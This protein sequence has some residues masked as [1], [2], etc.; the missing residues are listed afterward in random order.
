MA[1]GE[2]CVTAAGTI[3]NRDERFASFGSAPFGATTLVSVAAD[4]RGAIAESIGVLAGIAPIGSVAAGRAISRGITVGAADG[5]AR[6][7][8]GARRVATGGGRRITTGAG[9]RI[10]VSVQVATECIEAN[11]VANNAAV[12][13]IETPTLDHRGSDGRASHRAPS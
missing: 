5:F 6:L 3:T 10:M 12:A 2:A 1:P 7:G 8:A 9:E 11:A 13:T 4:A